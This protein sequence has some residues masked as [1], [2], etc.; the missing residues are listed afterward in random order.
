MSVISIGGLVVALVCRRLLLGRT[1]RQCAMPRH[2]GSFLS[3]LPGPGK[4]PHS[5]PGTNLN[6]RTL[7]AEEGEPRQKKRSRG[8]EG[9]ATRVDVG[10]GARV[11][12]GV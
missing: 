11:M 10:E 5:S 2:N 7:M 8:A 9:D 4:E 12:P 3:N 6:P 1:P